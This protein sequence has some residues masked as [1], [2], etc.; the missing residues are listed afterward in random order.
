M[1]AWLGPA[2]ARQ[3][4]LTHKDFLGESRLRVSGQVPRG[5]CSQPAL[6]G[7]RA[8]SRPEVTCLWERGEDHREAFCQSYRIFFLVEAEFQP[9]ESLRRLEAC[10]ATGFS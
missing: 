7:A 6:G 9:G 10:D 8:G 1:N 2:P 4:H 5:Q 3:P